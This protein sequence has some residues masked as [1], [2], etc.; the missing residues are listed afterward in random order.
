MRPEPL[1]FSPPAPIP[2]QQYPPSS[3]PSTIPPT[4]SPE[5]IV[6]EPLPVVQGPVTELEVTALIDKVKGLIEEAVKKGK[7]VATPNNMLRLA[8]S[9][10]RS[11]ELEKAK[12]YA[13]KTRQMVQDMLKN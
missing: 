1:L 6:E 11:H 7:D 10:Q 4:V 12:S 13:E 9:F 5:V 8:A 3:G 2:P